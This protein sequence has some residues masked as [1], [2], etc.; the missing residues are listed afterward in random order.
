MR[1]LQD[2]RCPRTP[3]RL[4]VHVRHVPSMPSSLPPPPTPNPIGCSRGPA[5]PSSCRRQCLPTRHARP[6]P[7]TRR[8]PTSSAKSPGPWPPSAQR[9]AGPPSPVPRT[10]HPRRLRPSRGRQRRPSARPTGPRTSN[11]RRRSNARR[12]TAPRSSPGSRRPPWP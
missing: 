9:Q 10:G 5:M 12:S 2:A 7:A 1:D 3:S 11:P 6:P 4:P 8:H